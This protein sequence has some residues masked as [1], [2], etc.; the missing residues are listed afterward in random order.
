MKIRKVFINT[1]AFIALRDAKDVNHN[2]AKL[3]LNNI[4][5]DNIKL[6]T[7]NFILDEV[8]TYFCRFH[9][10]ALEMADYILNSPDIIEYHRI[11]QQDEHDALKIARKYNDKAF[12]FTDCT[13]F[14]IC[15]RLNI[16]SVFAFDTHFEQ[17]GRLKILA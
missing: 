16:N 15:N 17:L 9:E 11:S 8:Y 7:T 3:I 13:S 1:S 10:V 4:R 6:I 14:S 2:E 12:S 5:T